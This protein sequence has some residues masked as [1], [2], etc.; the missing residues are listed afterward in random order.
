MIH[1]L[2]DFCLAA[3]VMV[4]AKADGKELWAIVLHSAIHAVL[5]GFFYPEHLRLVRF[6]DEEQRREFMFQTNAMDLTAK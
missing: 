1:Y 4:R 2:A 3:P 5:M 6:F